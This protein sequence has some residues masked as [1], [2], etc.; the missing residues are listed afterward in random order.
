MEAV[1][2]KPARAKI[3]GKQGDSKP[4]NWF[5]LSFFKKCGGFLRT[6]GRMSK[7]E[8]ERFSM[9]QELFQ[10]ER[11]PDGTVLIKPLLAHGDG[12]REG[13]LGAFVFKW[14]HSKN[15]GETFSSNVGIDLPDGSTR[16]PDAVWVSDERLVGVSGEEFENEFLKAVPDFVAEFRTGVDNL[17]L[18]KE[19][20]S[21]IWMKNGVRLAW[22]IDPY[23]EKTYIYREGQEDPEIVEGFSGK[24]LSG[25]NV[26][27]GF[28]F[29]LDAVKLK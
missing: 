16:S 6:G 14:Q 20:M 13:A 26:M 25:E 3:A 4:E 22:L 17:E 7:K 10:M 24:K 1:M 19:K 2:E 11:E 28:E 9:S 15:T 12:S 23:E 5:P 18:V 21:F 29:P 8:F 27:P